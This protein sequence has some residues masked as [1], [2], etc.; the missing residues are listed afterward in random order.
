MSR[1]VLMTLACVL[2]LGSAAAMAQARHV[3]PQTTTA[4]AQKSA[5]PQA[6]TR[7]EQRHCL[8][9]T[10]SLIRAKPGQCLTGVVGRSYSAKELRSTGQ[11]NTA[12]ALRMLDPAIH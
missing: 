7:P 5:P 2:G 10:G 9:D 11:I 12:D 3:D 1:I 8:R 6:A 4:A